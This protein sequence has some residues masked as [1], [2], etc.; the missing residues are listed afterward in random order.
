MKINVMDLI[1][2]VKHE[3]ETREAELTTT[4]TEVESAF[5]VE[6]EPAQVNPDILAVPTTQRKPPKV[7][8]TDRRETEQKRRT[9]PSPL[10]LNYAYQ[11]LTSFNMEERICGRCEP[12]S[13]CRFMID[14]LDDELRKEFSERGNLR[15]RDWNFLYDDLQRG[16]IENRPVTTQ[17]DSIIDG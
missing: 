13:K 5:P 7:A 3:N 8:P 14:W 9:L 6:D 16:T 2:S 12:V 17:F 10:Q 11:W 1:E 4:K 15:W